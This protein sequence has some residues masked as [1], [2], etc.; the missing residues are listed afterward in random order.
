MLIARKLQAK[1]RIRRILGHGGSDYLQA[2]FLQFIDRRA[3]RSIFE[4]GARD[5]RE[6]LALRDCLRAH[7]TAFECNP[8]AIEICRKMLD[9]AHSVELVEKA[10][11]DRTGKSE[12]DPVVRSKDFDGRPT[13]DGLGNACVNIGASS[14]FIARDDYLQTYQQSHTRVPA[15]RLEEYCANMKIESIDLLCIDLQGAALNA[16]NGLGRYIKTVRY[17]IVELEHRPLYQN[18]P[19]YSDTHEFLAANGFRQATLIRRDDWFSDYLYVN[20]L[21]QI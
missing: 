7:V 15:I 9:N 8:Q 18:Q 13:T 21:R 11:G 14:C 4:L 10:A 19:L 16:L 17:L 20:T 1:V 12:C 6:T 2:E 5:G 3:V